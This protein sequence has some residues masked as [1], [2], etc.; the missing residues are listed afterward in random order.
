MNF[1]ARAIEKK[2][3]WEGKSI[4]GGMKDNCH[5]ANAGRRIR[6]SV[7]LRFTPTYN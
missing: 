7:S 3:E 6:T 4:R 5:M 2:I 1:D